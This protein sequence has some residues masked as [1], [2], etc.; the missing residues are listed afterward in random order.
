M[1]N[2]FGTGDDHPADRV[3]A[4]N[5]RIVVNLDPLRRRFEFEQLAEFAKKTPLRAGVRK[6][7]RQRLLGIVH[8]HRGQLAP[9]AALRP[10]DPHPMPGADGQRL[11]KKILFLGFVGQQ[12]FG[13]RVLVVVELPEKGRQNG[14][15]RRVGIVGQEV[16]PVAVIRSATDEEGLDAGPLAA[17]CQRDD[18]GVFQIRNIDVLAG[19]NAR[20]GTDAVSPDGRRFELQ[21]VGGV[22]HACGVVALDLGRCPGQEA[23]RLIKLRGVVGLTDKPDTG[24]AASLDLILQA[25]T[26]AGVEDGIGTGA[27]HE[28]PSKVRHRAVDRARRREGAEIIPLAGLAATMFRQLAERMVGRQQDLR[29][30]LV[31]AKKDVVARFQL[32][33]QVRLKKQRLD[34]GLG[35][36]H[37]QRLGLADHA[38]QS[39]RQ[40]VRLRVAGHPARQIARLADIERLADTVQH[41][42]DPGVAGQLPDLGL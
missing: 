2:P 38:H 25:R 41:P 27:Q 28:G 30:A 32:L 26:R 37:F 17:S 18:V 20:Q 29:Q 33:D 13:R 15:G 3:A 23:P 40:A 8:R 42:V 16:G 39:V 12:N 36:D 24:A 6:I 14:G 10:A 1:L 34:L 5:V 4:L 21:R 35:D 22:V 9:R 11:A 7:A 31:V 19:L